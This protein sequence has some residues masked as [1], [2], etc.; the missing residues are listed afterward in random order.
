MVFGMKFLRIISNQDPIMGKLIRLAHLGEVEE[1]GAMHRTT[2]GTMGRLQS[3]KFGIASTGIEQQ[4]R[5]YSYGCFGCN[6]ERGVTYRPWLGNV[7]VKL[8]ILAKPFSIVSIDPLGAISCHPS[9]GARKTVK[10]YPLMI[11]CRSSGATQ[12]FLMEGMDTSDVILALL[13]LENRFGIT[14]EK[15]T[16]DAGTN[17]LGQNINPELKGSDRDRLFGIMTTIAHPVN[18]QFRN[19]CERNTAIVKKWIRQA[20]MISKKSHIPCT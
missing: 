14:L 11:V 10:V 1:K 12:V 13:R 16:V 20:T 9:K 19:Y 18:S 6:I 3:G 15:I 2:S 17:L 5:D 7:S 4:I 8:N